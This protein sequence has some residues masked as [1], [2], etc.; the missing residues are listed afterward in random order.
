MARC[1]VSH[2]SSRAAGT[3]WAKLGGFTSPNKNVSTSDYPDDIARK[4]AQALIDAGNNFS[5]DMSDLAPA[6]FGGTDGSG[7]WGDLQNWLMRLARN[8]VIDDY[9]RRQRTP[10]DSH[11]E[12]LA[13]HPTDFRGAVARRR[14]VGEGIDL[15]VLVVGGLGIVGNIR[16][17][18]DSGLR[19]QGKTAANPPPRPPRPSRR[20]RARPQWTPPAR[21]WTKSGT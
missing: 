16:R 14:A 9:R 13:D 12:D 5:F 4:S 3:V 6:A 21:R 11:A 2:V 15:E 8:L 19:E 7:E 18:C 17:T 1:T 20:A 10:H